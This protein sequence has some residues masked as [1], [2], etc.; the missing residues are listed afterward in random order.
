MRPTI[1]SGHSLMI[2]NIFARS[3]E[4]RTFSSRVYETMRDIQFRSA[5]AQNVFPAPCSTIARAD[6]VSMFEKMSIASAISSSLN[7][8]WTPGRLRETLSTPSDSSTVSVLYAAMRR[9]L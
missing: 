9:A 6:A 1:G 2:A 7:A 3:E 8:L 5:P 4:S